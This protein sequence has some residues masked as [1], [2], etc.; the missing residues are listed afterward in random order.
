MDIADATN[1]RL[2]RYANDT[3]RLGTA[4]VIAFAISAELREARLTDASWR[5]P[6]AIKS[7]MA[8]SISF[9]DEALA[10]ARSDMTCFSLSTLCFC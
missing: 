10:K 7:S 6:S 2:I 5:F 4:D 1:V 8:R 9:E 3:E